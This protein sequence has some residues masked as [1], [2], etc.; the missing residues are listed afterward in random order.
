MEKRTLFGVCTKCD[1]LLLQDK[2]I[3]GKVKQVFTPDYTNVTMLLNDG[4]KMRVAMCR[5]CADSWVNSE[6]ERN[7][8]MR[9]VW[10]GWQH[11]VETFAEWDEDKKKDYL[12][13]YSK[14]RILLRADTLPGDVIKEVYTNYKKNEPKPKHILKEKTHGT[15]K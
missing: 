14:K 11:E 12:D 1:K 10:R 3:D 4:S 5:G 2:A 9:K 6:D 15:R 13:R 8:I 7:D